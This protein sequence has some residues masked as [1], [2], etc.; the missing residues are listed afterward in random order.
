MLKDISNHP[1]LPT[2]FRK[3]DLGA[4]TIDY[5]AQTA[6]WPFK[7]RHY[8]DAGME[9]PE[10]PA[11]NGQFT[12]GGSNMVD[13]KTGIKST[14]PNAIPEFPFLIGML[15]M[16]GMEPLTLGLMRLGITDQRGQFNDYTKL[17][18]L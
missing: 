3:I 1:K 17:M 10:V 2:V 4:M 14:E 9:M 6:Y 7:I 15:K 11:A 18:L 5:D 16:A 12:I 8:D 13:P